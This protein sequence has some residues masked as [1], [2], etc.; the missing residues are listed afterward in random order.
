[1]TNHTVEYIKFIR[2]YLVNECYNII[3]RESITL[4]DDSNKNWDNVFNKVHKLLMYYHHISKKIIYAPYQTATEY[5][6][7]SFPE[8]VDNKIG[9]N[10][11]TD[12]DYRFFIKSMSDSVFT[13]NLNQQYNNHNSLQMVKNHVIYMVDLHIRGEK[14][15][16]SIYFSLE[17]RRILHDVLNAIPFLEYVSV[18][19][20]KLYNDD[21]ENGSPFDVAFN[22]L[23]KDVLQMIHANL[24]LTSY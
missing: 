3:R 22:I 4:T 10:S 9:I 13:Y 19:A 16:D 18:N 23:E 8:F 5:K 2:D 20:Y 7:L 6:Y 17:E 12:A 21:V 1:M 14:V 11:V 15:N 24:Y